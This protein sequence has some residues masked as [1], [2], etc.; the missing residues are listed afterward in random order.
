MKDPA[1]ANTTGAFPNVLF[2][3][4]SAPG[5]GLGTPAIASWVQDLIGWPQAL[6]DHVGETPDGV[7]ETG[8]SSQ[9]LTALTQLGAVYPGCL[10]PLHIF[11]DPG[12]L[13]PTPRLLLLTGQ[14]VLIADYP[15]LVAATYQGNGNNPTAAAYYKTSDTP[16]TVRDTAGPYF[17]LPDM[18][19]Y[20]PRGLDVAAA[21]DPDGASRTLADTQADAFDAHTHVIT[22]STNNPIVQNG[23]PYDGFIP[24]ATLYSVQ[25]GGTAIIIP[26]LVGSPTNPVI[27]Q[28]SVTSPT[29]SSG[30]SE[31]R[32]TNISVNWAVVY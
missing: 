25:L 29:G 28:V 1:V 2:Q 30:G 17:V 31:T 10:V 27:D 3:D 22:N 21:V 32:M 5:D 8:A 9:L 26:E 19:G 14:T 11:A 6:L 18:R 15:E 4:I 13:S 20:A 16:G 24:E 12:A 7:S 23:G